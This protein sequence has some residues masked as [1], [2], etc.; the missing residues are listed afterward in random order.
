[1]SRLVLRLPETLHRQVEMLARRE[2]TSLDQSLVYALTRQAAEAYTS[3]EFSEEA[4][5]QPRAA[6]RIG[7]YYR[8]LGVDEEGDINWIW[9]ATHAF[10]FGGE[11]PVDEEGDINWIWIG[12][13]AEYDKII[14]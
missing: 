14:I 10:T 11:A 2:Q 1:M 13:H 4:S 9:I 8:A 12:T 6:F 7:G 5:A 3:H